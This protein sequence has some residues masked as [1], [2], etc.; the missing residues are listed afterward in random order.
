MTSL[1]V[2]CGEHEQGP[3]KEVADKEFADRGEAEPSLTRLASFTSTALPSPT[4][5]HASTEEL[6]GAL[7]RR[8]SFEITF[9]PTASLSRASSG[10][11]EELQLQGLKS[12][13]SNEALSASEDAVDLGRTVPEANT[14]VSRYKTAGLRDRLVEM[15]SGQDI[16]TESIADG[17]TGSV[18]AVEVSGEKVAVFKPEQGEKFT[19]R[20]LDRGQGYVREEVVYLVDR[21]SGSQAGVPVT[22]QAAIGVEGDVLQGSVQAFVGDVIGCVEDFAMPRDARQANE[23]I[24]QET[25]EALALLDM[26]IFNMDRHTGNLLLLGREAPH[27]LGPIDHGCCLPP[28]WKLGEANFDAWCG[29]AQLQSSPCDSSREL[30]RE[31]AQDLPRTCAMARAVGLEESAVLTLQL[32]TI[33]V[34]IGVGELG[35]PCGRLAA[36]ML[37]DEETGFREL[38]W[39]ESKVLECACAVGAR[40]CV[41]VSDKGEQEIV[42]E[43]GSQEVLDAEAFLAGLGATFRAL[44]AEAAWAPPASRRRAPA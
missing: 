29:W 12:S 33:F 19:R 7:T 28:W 5:S 44:V 42:L 6:E 2:P 8:S 35:V 30:A 3:G 21:I 26:R 10:G 40:C 18:Y 15:V 24:S 36:L 41:R 14:R 13:S 32:C 11:F 25:A 34:M 17:Q 9:L 16:K 39:L 23:F 1:V 20:S 37:R 31:A 22:A 38:S 27:G 43:A 4:L